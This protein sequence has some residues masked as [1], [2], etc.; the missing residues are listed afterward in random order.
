MLCCVVLCCAAFICFVLFCFDLICFV[1]HRFVVSCGIALCCCVLVI[2]QGRLAC[3][4]SAAGVGR[5]ISKAG[6]AGNTA[7][8][9]PQD[10]LLG[11]WSSIAWWSLPSA[12]SVFFFSCMVGPGPNHRNQKNGKPGWAGAQ[13]SKEE[14]GRLR[15]DFL[16]NCPSG[17]PKT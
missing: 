7:E 5:S 2:S 8:L 16:T 4:N 1:L 9:S 11:W 15:K 13:P 10:K 12:S 17:W 3:K 6:A 14:N